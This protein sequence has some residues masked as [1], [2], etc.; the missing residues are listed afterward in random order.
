MGRV[1]RQAARNGRELLRPHGLIGVVAQDS[2]ADVRRIM[3]DHMRRQHA[4]RPA[5]VNLAGLSTLFRDSQV[6]AQ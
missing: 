4:E 6:F 2:H 1:F 5:F 3:P